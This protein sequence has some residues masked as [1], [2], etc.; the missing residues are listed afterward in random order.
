MQT[1]PYCKGE[2][3]E[4]T[5]FCNHCGKNIEGKQTPEEKVSTTNEPQ[6]T[7]KN[8]EVT[9]PLVS[10]ENDVSEKKLPKK[11][12]D[13]KMKIIMYSSI[14]IIVLLIGAS[15]FG[16]FQSSVDQVIKNFETAV[17]D[18][19]TKK[20]EDMLTIDHKDLEITAE[21][22]EGF[23][24]LYESQPSEL[25]HLTNNLK[26][27]AGDGGGLPNMFPVDLIKDGKKFIFYDNYKLV[28]NP[29]YIKAS[30]NYKDTDIII[31][32]EVLAT[33]DTDNYSSEVGPIIPGE[34]VI[35]AVYDTGIFHLEAEETVKASDPGFA[36][37]VDLRLD[38]QNITFDLLKNRYNDLKTIKLFINGKD[39]EWN[40]A[41]EDRV[42]PLLTDGTMNASFEADL[43]WGTIRTND[44]PLDD[45]YFS[46][47]LGNSDEFQ[48]TIMDQ[49]ILFNEEFIEAYASAEP[50]KMTKATDDLAI[51]IAED[52]VTSI[53][54]GTEYTG[55]YHGTDF[56]TDSFI[57]KQDYDGFWK[58][59]VDTITYFEEAFYEKDDKPKEEKNEEEIRYEL[60]YDPKTKEWFVDDTDHAGSMEEDKM[61]R[62]KVSDPVVHKSDWAK[63]IKEIEDASDLE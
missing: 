61:E 49:I 32:G 56:Y 8:I 59:T 24:K 29:V 53:L 30:T 2:V 57:L 36:Q 62:H 60:I 18:K 58:V 3:S 26:M 54:S 10:E 38:G 37:Y 22:L 1:C 43:P 17:K 46:F 45:S 7:P 50:E 28:V 33:T 16:K 5:K 14:A 12:L 44:V 63:I 39:T 19:D 52:M 48:K 25:N 6:Q 55:A 4:S 11:K 27:Q 15:I 51:S 34:H 35:E 42:G 23:V 9:E 47:N 40:I 21:S 31:N 20:L 13:K 41:K